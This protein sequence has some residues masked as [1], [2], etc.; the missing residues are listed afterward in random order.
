VGVNSPD[1]CSSSLPLTPPPQ[2]TDACH[3]FALIG[4]GGSGGGKCGLG[5]S[6]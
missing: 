3:T 5:T 4:E 1:F 2:D 6:S